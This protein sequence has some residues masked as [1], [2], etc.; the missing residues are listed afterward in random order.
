LK[1]LVSLEGLHFFAFH[2]FYD[3]ERKKGNNFICDV[4]V[5]LKSFDSMDD[6]IFDTVNYED[7]YA[8]A[9]EEMKIT[10]KLIETV[11][12]NIIEKIKLLDNVT[13]A[14]VRIHKL[15]PPIKGKVE[16]A[17]VEMRF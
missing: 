8:I 10:R 16:K 2:G 17:V 9:E 14:V 15:N 13:G 5:E 12:Y 6:N 7:V 1:T 4:Q 11:A 3:E